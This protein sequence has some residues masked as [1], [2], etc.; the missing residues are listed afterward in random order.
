MRTLAAHHHSACI[1]FFMRIKADSTTLTTGKVII[2][3]VKSTSLE[4]ELFG[5][6]LFS[7]GHNYTWTIIGVSSLSAA[8]VNS[9]TSQ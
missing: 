3:K 9:N 5:S 4:L 1:W 2:R 8:A 7:L 6:Y